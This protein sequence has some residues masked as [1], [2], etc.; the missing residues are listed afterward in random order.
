MS[1]KQND[2][3]NPLGTAL[4][5]GASSGIGKAIA[6]RLRKE[7]Y[8]VYGTSRVAGGRQ[9]DQEIH[10]LQLEGASPQGR[11]A[12]LQ[13][14]GSL[15]TSVDI[16]INNAGSSLFG[17]A[18]EIPSSEIEAQ[19]QLLLE[20]PLAFTRVALGGMLGRGQGTIVNVSSL[21]AL[22]PLP[23]M[24]DYSAAK[25]ALSTYSQGLQAT[26]KGSGIAIID[27]QPGDFKTPFNGSIRQFGA[28]SP[29][30]RRA[31]DRLEHNMDGAPPPERAAEDL[32]GAILRGK[33]CTLRSGGAFQQMIAPLGARIL[34]Q[35]AVQ[36]LIR[37]YYN[38]PGK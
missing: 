26:L 4:V 9:G 36:G 27:F 19:Y 37:R 6:G 3:V 8:R 15:L 18:S 35:R 10:W 12:F 16:L 21:A 1:P 31:W 34:P 28:L 20:T 7:G 13:A 23:Y 38:L 5:T 22:F 25:A 30:Q 2:P 17:S 33:S 24:E 14:H 29:S 11:Q 32:V